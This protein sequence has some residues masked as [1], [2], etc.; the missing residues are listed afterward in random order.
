SS[1][2][3]Q[4]TTKEHFHKGGRP[5]IGPPP[6]P[7]RAGACAQRAPEPSGPSAPAGCNL[8]AGDLGYEGTASSARPSSSQAAAPAR[9]DSRERHPRPPAGGGQP[10]RGRPPCAH[11]PA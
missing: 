8:T 5:P 4:T 11:R 1:T 9:R 3:K 7:R 6:F 10:G 2:L